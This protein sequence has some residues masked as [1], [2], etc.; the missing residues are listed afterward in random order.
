MQ[1][2]L[3]AGALSLALGL[4]LCV[5]VVLAAEPPLPLPPK[6][7]TIPQLITHYAALYEVSETQLY[8][9]LK[10]ESGLYKD[11]VGDYGASYGIAQIHLPS[12]PNISKAQALDPDFAI[13]FA[14]KEFAAGNQSAWTCFRILFW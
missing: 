9:T 11:A 10:C 3:F 1:L 6:P 14:A 4:S 2:K 5:P 7:L 12:H 13:R 8:K